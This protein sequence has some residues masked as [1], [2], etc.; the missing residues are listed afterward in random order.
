VP[1]DPSSPDV[2]PL[3]RQQLDLADPSAHTFWHWVRFDIVTREAE[4]RGADTIVDIGAGSG[5]FGDRLANTHPGLVYRFD[6][7][8]PALGSALAER[9]GPDARFG[10]DER[11]STTMVACM[12]DVV[13][14]IEH[15]VDAL[16]EWR[17]RME[18]GTPLVVNVPALQ[19]AFSK[20]DEDLGHFRRYSRKRLRSTLEAAGFEV[21]RCDYLFPELLPTVTL[22]RLRPSTNT[23]DMPQMSER[24]NKLGHA[25]SSSTA[26]AR[27]IW[28][29]GTSV[30]AVA[31]AP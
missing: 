22:R 24:M 12:L 21:E 18:S 10:A 6:E 27:R 17:E 8:S 15:D 16:I 26:K 19:W 7:L 9:Y 30:V 29:G 1:V 2:T 13:E 28:P 4:R 25:I 5:M 14:H 20:F 11:I 31:I 23:V 3:E